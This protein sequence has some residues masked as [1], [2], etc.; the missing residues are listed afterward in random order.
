MFDG[1]ARACPTQQF[2]RHQI[3]RDHFAAATFPRPCLG[4]VKS[5][6]NR[7]PFNLFIESKGL[8]A[9]FDKIRNA[10]SPTGRHDRLSQRDTDFG[11]STQNLTRMLLPGG[12]SIRREPKPDSKLGELKKFRIITLAG[13]PG[14]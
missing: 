10:K 8:G 14:E 12:G 3:E 2:V 1:P 4:T 11:Q 7:P 6:R 9:L 5:Q 13:I